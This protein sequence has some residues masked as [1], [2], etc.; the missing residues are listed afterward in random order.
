MHGPRAL[1]DLGA[2]DENPRA[3]LGELER[4]LRREPHLAAAGESRS[5]EEEREPDAAIGAG[6]RLAPAPEVGAPHRFAEHLD[7]AAVAAEALARR[8][9][10]A[11][12]Q[13]V[14][15]ADA[16]R[17]DAEPLGDPVHVRL[18]GELRLRRAEP[19]ERAVGRR[20]R[21]RRAPADAD[22]VAAV[23]TRRVQHTT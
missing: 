2:R 16:H 17:I 1:A 3:A 21:H 13:R 4:R 7:R 22:V 23:R 18:D 14:D 8:G 9:R 6:E 10:V 5:V 11:R 12:T 15:L 19:A 20:V